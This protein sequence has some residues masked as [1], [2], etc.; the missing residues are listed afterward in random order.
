MHWLFQ[1]ENS[2]DEIYPQKTKGWGKQ[3]WQERETEKQSR[4]L[5]KQ[6][7]TATHEKKKK[8]L[9]QMKEYIDCWFILPDKLFYILNHQHFTL[10]GKLTQQFQSFHTS[11]LAC[12]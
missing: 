6:F 3:K 4:S 2:K 9:H 10:A 1:K 7:S 12:P 8:M 5:F 11:A